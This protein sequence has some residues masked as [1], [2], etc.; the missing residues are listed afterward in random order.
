MQ[1][2]RWQRKRQ[3]Q[4]GPGTPAPA[5]PA[6]SAP[7]AV[8]VAFQQRPRYRLRKSTSHSQPQVQ[9]QQQSKQRRSPHKQQQQQGPV[10]S[11]DSIPAGDSSNSSSWP[12]LVLT[13]ESA[14]QLSAAQSVLQ[15]LY[16]VKEL[17]A[18]L[19]E[20]A[21]E[22]QLQVALLADM[23]QVPELTNAAVQE[24]KG[25]VDTH[26]QLSDVATQQL[27]ALQAVPEFLQALVE[28]VLLIKL[29]DLQV[30]WGDPALATALLEM[31]LPVMQVFLSLGKLQVSCLRCGRY[32]HGTLSGIKLEWVSTPQCISQE[33][34]T[35]PGLCSRHL[36]SSCSVLTPLL[37]TNK[38][39]PQ[40]CCTVLPFLLCSCCRWPRRTQCCT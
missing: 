26:G 12:Q 6:A 1:I 38:T 37:F 11:S 34:L 36:S 10:D 32:M 18:L 15:A 23:W 28:R 2:E 22:Q 4:E 17:P 5:I 24:L 20:L 31:S 16:C 30:V 9:Q 21:Q 8:A 19:S 3:H 29:G 33:G 35:R 13:L 27:F 14:D 25:S 40:L 7:A 39:H